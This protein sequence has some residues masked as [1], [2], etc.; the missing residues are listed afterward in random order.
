MGDGRSLAAGGRL[1]E[2]P[3]TEAAIFRYSS[4]R[5]SRLP[6]LRFFRPKPS[7][8]GLQTGFPSFL[9]SWFLSGSPDTPPS[10]S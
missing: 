5:R 8:L 6:V 1:D 2:I 9:P 7:G 10:I 3:F 4:K